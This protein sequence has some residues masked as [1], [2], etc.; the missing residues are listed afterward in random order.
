MLVLLSMIT[1]DGPMPVAVVWSW[2]VCMEL[3]RLAANAAAVPFR[4]TVID[5]PGA[6][7]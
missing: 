5:V 1:A 6:G 4:C 2:D 7:A 3:A